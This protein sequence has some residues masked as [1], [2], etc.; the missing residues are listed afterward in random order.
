VIGPDGRSPPMPPTG[1]PAAAGTPAPQD[2]VLA[3]EA[4]APARRRRIRSFV[5]GGMIVVG[6]AAGITFA[7]RRPTVEP[8]RVAL[9]TPTATGA[10]APP[11]P[12]APPPVAPNEG[13]AA[14][15]GEG[16]APEAKA[17][18]AAGGDTKASKMK[19][20]SAKSKQSKH[21]HPPKR[22]DPVKW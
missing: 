17:V 16:E 10:P 21:R 6:C 14:K 3:Y 2:S 13:E 12:V 9:P 8:Q 11:L 1:G 20:T 4:V 15:D 5:V 22:K 19:A 18:V 7:L